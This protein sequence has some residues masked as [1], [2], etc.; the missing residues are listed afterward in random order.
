ML[1]ISGIIVIS[2]MPCLSFGL[3]SI[4]EAYTM[5]NFLKI[6]F[7]LESSKGREK[8]REQNINV[9]EK[10]QLVAFRTCP[11]RD[12]IYNPS[13]C[14]GIKP[15][16]FCFADDAQPTEPHRPAHDNILLR[17]YRWHIPLSL[18]MSENISIFP[19]F[20]RY[21]LIPASRLLFSFNIWNIL[22]H[23]PLNFLWDNWNCPW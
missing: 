7:I 13:I 22:L 20:L 2:P 19:S 4:M 18:C 6:F 9:R 15:E 16:T 3:T 17:V 21:S 14:P 5:K 8:E 11:N 10:Y 1:P 12:Q 23:S